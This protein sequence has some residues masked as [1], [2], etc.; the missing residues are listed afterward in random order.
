MTI[1]ETWD[2]KFSSYLRNGRGNVG[3]WPCFG[4]NEGDGRLC[5]ELVHGWDNR[6][7]ND[8][9]GFVEVGWKP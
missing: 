4:T 6:G 2:D 8:R 5:V 9:L 7:D 3:T 1:F